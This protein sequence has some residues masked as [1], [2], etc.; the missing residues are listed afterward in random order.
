MHQQT[1]FPHVFCQFDNNNNNNNNNSNNFII[2]IMTLFKNILKFQMNTNQSYQYNLNCNAMEYLY[3]NNNNNNNCKNIASNNECIDEKQ[4][5][6]SFR[7]F[8]RAVFLPL[9]TYLYWEIPKGS[10]II[11]PIQVGEITQLGR[12]SGSLLSVLHFQC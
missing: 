4:F 10:F 8:G 6:D 9:L 2:I 1:N 5:I 11:Q 3:N 7:V 12:S